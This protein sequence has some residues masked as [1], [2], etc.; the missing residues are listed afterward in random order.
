MLRGDEVATNTPGVLNSSFE[1]TLT[2]GGEGD[3]RGRLRRRG[4]SR[5]AP[6]RF[7][8]L[9]G[10]LY[11]DPGA[12]EAIRGAILGDE[13]EEE[14]LGEHHLAAKRAGLA[15]REDDGLDGPLGETLEDGGDGGPSGPSRETSGADGERVM[16]GPQRGYESGALK[17]DGI[18]RG[19]WNQVAEREAR[20]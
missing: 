15:L 11:G 10:A 18:R 20:V 5:L 13:A 9:S 17:R 6:N 8:S 16:V 12:E 3:V 14:V 1:D 19:K 4:R 2:A 7:N